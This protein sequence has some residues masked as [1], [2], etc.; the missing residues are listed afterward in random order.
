[1]S[2]QLYS[3]AFPAGEL[4]PSKYTCDGEDISPPLHWK[5][6]PENT[7]S[8]ALVL[9]DPDAPVGTWDHWVLYNLPA[10]TAALEEGFSARSDLP[11][12]CLRGINSWRKPGYGGPCPPAG[13]HRYFFKLYALDVVLD[14]P[15][16]A[17]KAQLLTAMERHILDQVELMGI[18]SR[19]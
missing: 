12:G 13:T 2:F 1:M 3:P 4:I 18:Y 16:G 9:D 6:A 10:E 17:T 14:L 19:K 15:F 11:E 5:N 8:F 7:R